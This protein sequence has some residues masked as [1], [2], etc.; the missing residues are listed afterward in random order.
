MLLMGIKEYAVSRSISDKLIRK[1]VAD[2]VVS[3]SRSGR[4]YLLVPEVVDEQI[5]KFFSP[6]P[7]PQPQEPPAPKIPKCGFHAAL[8]ALRV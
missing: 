5:K 4:K 2:G 3:F 8:K 7:E 6:Q 1:L